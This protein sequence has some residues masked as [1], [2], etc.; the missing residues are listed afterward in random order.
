MFIGLPCK[1]CADY[2]RAS[3]IRLFGFG[4]SEKIIF[5]TESRGFSR[6]VNG[7]DAS[8]LASL[9]A[10]GRRPNR[11]GARKVQELGVNP[12]AHWPVLMHP[13]PPCC[14]PTKA[15]ISYSEPRRSRSRAWNGL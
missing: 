12:A 5:S 4:L 1:V 15:G 2:Q 10:K 7:F 8:R 13:R 3:G 6:A 9:A 14:H 11:S